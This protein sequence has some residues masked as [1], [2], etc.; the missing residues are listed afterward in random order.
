[1]VLAKP[2]RPDAPDAAKTEVKD[3]FWDSLPAPAPPPA[4]KPAKKK[5]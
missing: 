1:V 4:A 2:R 3:A 5:K